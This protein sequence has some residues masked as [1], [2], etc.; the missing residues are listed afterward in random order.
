MQLCSLLQVPIR[1]NN[2]NSQTFTDSAPAVSNE[3]LPYNDGNFARS[4][5]GWSCV[6]R[7]QRH[8]RISLT[9]RLAKLRLNTSN[10]SITPNDFATPFLLRGVTTHC[11][12]NYAVFVTNCLTTAVMWQHLRHDSCVM[13]SKAYTCNQQF[14]H[15]HCKQCEL[16]AMRI[17][18]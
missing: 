12:R 16:F 11:L 14:Y 8:T 1:L 7:K 5:V 4:S 13:A 2:T 9:Y 17:K 3:M 6:F 18:D 15:K 10:F